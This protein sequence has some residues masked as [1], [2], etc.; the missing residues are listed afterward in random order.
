LEEIQIY[1][2]MELFRRNTEGKMFVIM[3]GSVIYACLGYTVVDVQNQLANI[4]LV[5]GEMSGQSV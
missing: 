2:K 5:N 1:V 4:A 3:K